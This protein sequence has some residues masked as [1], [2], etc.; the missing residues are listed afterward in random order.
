MKL[1]L[2]I[3]VSLI[4]LSLITACEIPRPGGDA[5]NIA[6]EIP[7]VAEP[8]VTDTPTVEAP[9]PGEVTPP[10]VAEIEPE[11]VNAVQ[12]PEAQVVEGSV[13]VKLNPQASIQARSAERGADGIMSANIPSLDQVLQEIGAT[14]LEPVIEE[15][16]EAANENIESFSTEA[17]GISQ[18]YSVSFSPDRDPVDVANQLSLDDTVEY[19]EPNYVAGITASPVEIPAFFTPNDQYFSFQWNMQAIQMPTAWD[20]ANGAGVIVAIIDTGI[21]F[22]APDLATTERLPGYDFLNDDA[23]PKD[24]QGHG[25]HVA[26]TVAQSTNNNLGVAG[27][28]FG[29]RLLPVKVLGSSGEG[30]YE[31]VIKGIIYAVDQGAKVINMSLAGRNPSNALRDAV[32]YAHDRGVVVVSA[33]GNSG[34]S[35]EFPAAY[36]DFVIAVGATRFDKTITAYSNFGPQ[37]D[38][39]APGGDVSIDQNGDGFGD[40]ILQNTFSS[41]G[42]GYSYRFFEGTSMASPHVAGVAA[43]LLSLKPDASPDEIK[44]IMMQT[45]DAD[46]GIGASGQFG[47]GLVQAANAIAAISGPSGEPTPTDTPT[48]TPP[49]TPTP[50]PTH[51]VEPISEHDGDLVTATFTPTP[52]LTP[53]PPP[54]PTT[55][56]PPPTARELLVNGGFE[57]DKGW[58]F[59]DTPIRGD[60]ETGVVHSGSR[61]A[62]VGATSGRDRFSFSSVWQQVT[63][64]PE[65]NQVTLTAYVYPVS[66]D[67][68]GTD[69]QNIMILNENFRVL[70]TLSSELSNSQAWELRTYNLSDLRGRTI[71]VYFSVV[72]RGHTGRLSAMYIDDVSLAWSP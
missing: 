25:T 9:P 29:A 23:D 22:G 46:P 33:A 56:A 60:Y 58:E 24:D 1:K 16:A 18:L 37:I 13:L 14:E 8:G 52:T 69:I 26:G 59:G 34:G 7:V 41:T 47:A 27:V 39:M 50:T 30:S 65:A 21:D 49:N 44:N 38:L 10:S 11:G 57:E 6:P 53:G 3:P 17:P 15:V 40:G 48:P 72:N 35:V 55:P 2:I 62:R 45:A 20:R 63:I 68:P 43:L 42:S 61:A 36:D 70:R 31:T 5:G 28:A 19:A 71:Y 51:T 64:P 32:Q 66:Q 12:A 54:S 67:R 4:T